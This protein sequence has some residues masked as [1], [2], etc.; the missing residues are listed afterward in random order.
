MV[1]LSLKTGSC[2]ATLKK[3][4]RGKPNNRLPSFHQSCAARNWLKSGWTAN[5]LL[6]LLRPLLTGQDTRQPGSR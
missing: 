1:V 4:R 6:Q 2:G 3:L 5:G